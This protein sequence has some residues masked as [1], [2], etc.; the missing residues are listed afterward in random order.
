MSELMQNLHIVLQLQFPVSPVKT[1]QEA[2]VCSLLQET[3]LSNVSQMLKSLQQACLEETSSTDMK[4]SSHVHKKKRKKEKVL[5]KT[6]A[7]KKLMQIHT[8][9]MSPNEKNHYSTEF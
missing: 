7:E 5:V 1:I 2:A 6:V 4:C 8:G 3:F 9:R